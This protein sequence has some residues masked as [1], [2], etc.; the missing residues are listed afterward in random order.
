MSELRDELT[1]RGLSTKGLKGELVDRLN[2]ALK[3]EE[4]GDY[5]GNGNPENE[6]HQSDEERGYEIEEREDGGDDEV[7]YFTQL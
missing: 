7:F 3:N 4:F 5:T 2:D 6:G 1:K